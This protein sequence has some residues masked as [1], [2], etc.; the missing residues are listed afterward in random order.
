MDRLARLT[1]DDLQ[2]AYMVFEITFFR[3]QRIDIFRCRVQTILI[4][5]YR[6]GIFNYS[7]VMMISIHWS[8]NAGETQTSAKNYVL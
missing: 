1:G 6:Q 8:V 4:I 3:I 5:T 2:A 7:C